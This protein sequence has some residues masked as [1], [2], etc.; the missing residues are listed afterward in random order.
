MAA[1]NDDTAVTRPSTSGGKR[2]LVEEDTSGK[3]VR[4]DDTCC[5]I[6]LDNQPRVLYSPC[7]HKCVCK[8]CD[9]TKRAIAGAA[10]TDDVCPICRTQIAERDVLDETIC[11]FNDSRQ[12]IFGRACV[13]TEEPQLFSDD[14]IRLADG[15]AA[16]SSS[17]RLGSRTQLWMPLIENR[18][19]EQR[20]LP[21]FVTAKNRRL[22]AA[23]VLEVIQRVEKTCLRT[24]PVGVL[25]INADSTAARNVML[26][27]CSFSNADLAN[28][29]VFIAWFRKR[30]AIEL[31]GQLTTR[32]NAAAA[33]TWDD[34]WALTRRALNDMYN[35]APDQPADVLT[36]R[37]CIGPDSGG[38]LTDR[39][40]LS[41]V[42]ATWSSWRGLWSYVPDTAAVMAA[43][44]DDKRRRPLYLH[45]FVPLMY[46]LFL[47]HR[48][49]K[50]P[51]V[52]LVSKFVRSIRIKRGGDEDYAQQLDAR[53][54]SMGRL[55]FKHNQMFIDVDLR[56]A[57]DEYDRA[58]ARYRAC[59]AAV[60]RVGDAMRRKRTELPAYPLYL[61]HRLMGYSHG[62]IADAP[63]DATDVTAH[64]EWATRCLRT[65][66][67]QHNMAEVFRSVYE[68]A[69]VV[70]DRGQDLYLYGNMETLVNEMHAAERAARRD[71][72][73]VLKLNE[74]YAGEYTVPLPCKNDTGNTRVVIT[75]TP[76]NVGALSNPKARSRMALYGGQLRNK[77][78]DI[79]VGDDESQ[80]VTSIRLDDAVTTFTPV[81]ASYQSHSDGF[82]YSMY[83]AAY[84]TV[85]AAVAADGA[86]CDD[87]SP[88]P[89]G[90]L[91]YVQSG[92]HCSQVYADLD[93]HFAMGGALLGFT[94]DQFCAD[95]AQ[96]VTRVA[97]HVNV[98][99]KHVYVFRSRTG[100]GSG[101]GSDNNSS[102]GSVETSTK[103]GLHL[104]APLIEGTVM[105]TAAVNQFVNV[106][107]MLRHSMPATLGRG[108]RTTR[109]F[110]PCVY[111]RNDDTV[112]Y[113]GHCFRSPYRGK[114]DGSRVLDCVYRS[115]GRPLDE[116]VAE[117]YRY[118]HGPQF[119]TLATHDGLEMLGVRVVRGTVITGVEGVNEITDEAFV[120]RATRDA[121]GEYVKK[122]GQ[123]TPMG[124]MREVNKRR[125]YFLSRDANDPRYPY[126]RQRL[127]DM[128]NSLLVT[129]DA[130]PQ[131]CSY[132]TRSV[133]ASDTRHSPHHLLAV[134]KKS[135]VVYHR[136][137]DSFCLEVDGRVWLPFCARRPHRRPVSRR[138]CRVQVI[139]YRGMIR[140]GFVGTCMKASCRA[141]SSNYIAES[142]LS[143]YGV[144]LS[145]NNKEELNA[146]IRATLRPPST[147][148]RYIICREEDDTGDADDAAGADG[149]TAV[150][151]EG[152]HVAAVIAVPQ[153]T[154][155]IPA[156]RS[157]DVS[158]KDVYAD[159]HLTDTTALLV[160][161][162]ATTN[163]NRNKYGAFISVQFQSAVNCATVTTDAFA[164]A[165]VL[166]PEDNMELLAD[167]PEYILEALQHTRYLD[168]KSHDNLAAV[169]LTR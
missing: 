18:Q 34:L 49:D 81:W 169:M 77:A 163:N 103:L 130:L 133:G 90:Q 135:R 71:Y 74:Y 65:L 113:R 102:S 88:Y 4:V 108:E 80:P 121:V 140:F 85:E 25:F 43:D 116:P 156:L 78:Y 100:E 22:K 125:L 42:L 60:Q 159:V 145:A 166:V 48:I 138:S 151:T 73:A 149:A 61:G 53:L 51:L 5:I 38:Y 99:V 28:R 84:E 144:H 62:C 94:V 40:G 114:A 89:L 54:R 1:E 59:Q 24:V 131:L 142:M 124:M 52:G 137:T 143:M 19:Q 168:Q 147:V 3:K 29:T 39:W 35:S 36:T 141:Q 76:V 150:H 17:S 128:L 20:H 14:V 154:G 11:E 72:A 31:N 56:E 9:E 152:H 10:I 110:D 136:E 112:A 15:M 27:E 13:S 115:D 83:N 129:S 23:I 70:C 127:E 58:C 37:A 33:H 50:S 96:L 126:E 157:C 160:V 139:Y 119:T 64:D 66:S 12:F 67:D 122:L 21:E 155:A 16:A 26:R 82:S 118:V 107:E 55:D 97:S 2:K 47:R 117:R 105:T 87:A 91:E 6:C 75:F 104:H 120:H 8:D 68:R 132:M 164:S 158:I 7:K 69:E 44:D 57:L 93:M 146:R 111:P 167:H 162:L 161:R 45:E 32:D 63:L 123:H 79:A 86:A 134:L 46:H 101:S 30:A 106:L 109:L 92:M 148:K 95:L 41:S 153:P 165:G 98:P